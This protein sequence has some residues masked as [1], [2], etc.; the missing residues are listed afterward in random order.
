MTLRI[1]LVDDNLMYRQALRM[2][3]DLQDGMEVV[4]EL[5]DG[6][7][8]LHALEQ[9]RPEVV[10]MDIG[11]QN[12]DGPTTTRQLLLQRPDLRIIGLSAHTGHRYAADM[13]AA[14]ALGYVV[15]GGKLADL[16]QAIRSAASGAL[17][18]DPLLGP[19]PAT[20]PDAN[21]RLTRP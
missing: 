2:L 17:Y 12:Q 19:Q 18:L 1:M 15:K 9:S 5:S 4:A 16:L 20:Q 7:G 11:M 8:A 13:L 10:C 6:R 21:S 14:G 3:L